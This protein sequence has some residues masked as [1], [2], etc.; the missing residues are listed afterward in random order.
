MSRLFPSRAPEGKELLH[1]M[2]GGVRWPE[3]I[4]A[5][6]DE[7]LTRVYEDLNDILGLEVEP[8]PLGVTVWP[9]A[10]PQPD[11]DHGAR[12]RWAQGLLAEAPGLALAGAY[13]QGV[14]VSDTLL[15]GVE[16]A[17]RLV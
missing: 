6:E 11:R 1:C 14:S 4:H 7:I 9:R 13:T 16:A 3:I 17:R 5:S 8:M 12:M 10:I 15:S 2:I